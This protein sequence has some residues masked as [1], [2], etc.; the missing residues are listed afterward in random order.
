MAP[1]AVGLAAKAGVIGTAAIVGGAAGIKTGL[2]AATLKAP[3]FL[4]KGAIPNVVAFA[5]LLKTKKR[6]HTVAVAAPIPVAPLPLAPPAPV[7]APPVYAPPAYAP[8]AIVRSG[9]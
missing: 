8:P 2:L 5:P 1:I 3:L 6:H 7:Y 9:Y 4:A